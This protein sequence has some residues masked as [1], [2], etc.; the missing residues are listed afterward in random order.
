MVKTGHN[1]KKRDLL[2]ILFSVLI[3]LLVNY[4]G[5]FAFH[6][7]D[8]TSE[9]RY[10]LNDETKKLLK[11]L[12]DVV[13][14]KVYLEGDFNS[15]FKRLRNATKEIL[16]EFRAYSN[17]EI[18]YEFINPSSNPDQSEKNKLYKQLYTKG[19][20]PVDLRDAT[21]EG[22]KS[23]QI[24]FPGAII[25]HKGHDVAW[26]L[27]Q[28]QPG[29]SPDEQ[30]NNS[31]QSLEYG[32]SNGIRKL[33]T[34]IKK[35]IAFIEGHGELD[36]L[37]TK[38]IS[39]HLNEYYD[40]RRVSI[41]SN[42]H[43]LDGYKC[44]IIAKPDSTFNEKDKFIIDQFIMKGGSV[45]WLIDPLYTP[46]DSLRYYGQTYSLPYELNIEDQLF[47]YGVRINNNLILDI[48]C[49][50]I[51]HN[52][53]VP[54]QRPQLRRAPWFFSPLINYANDHI[55]T[56]NLDLIKFEY[57]SSIDTVKTKLATKKTTL[58]ASSKYSK[59]VNAPVRINLGIV[60]MQPDQKQFNNS[61]IPVALLVEGNFESLYKNRIPP[62]IVD[63]KEIGY[64]AES[65]T[66][67]M[68]F[69]SDGDII[70]NDYQPN[71]SQTF[72]LGFD[73]NRQY[74]YANKNFILNSINYLCDDEGL[75]SVRSREVKLRLL[76]KTRIKTESTKWQMI[77]TIIPVLIIILLGFLF[78]YLRNKKYT[79]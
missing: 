66:T 2:N 47:K 67:K 10:T 70:R 20:M 39:D 6:R 26:Q 65:K 77:N 3:L 75:I 15:G 59:F 25:T 52:V 58:L 28:A 23:S 8:L 48:Q 56:K 14:V 64:K 44:I 79:N 46:V 18:E 57:A 24:I 41:D 31:V 13:F 62:Q 78:L 7:F 19:L 36:T 55:I 21:E 35:K 43:A 4:I 49:S 30:L 63:N 69:V 53:A 61:Y 33:Q 54:G 22:G 27:L 37:D 72:P 68:I 50:E 45:L 5:S 9:K 60:N 12:D 40:T 38:D 73:F 76:D 16:D 11:E 42:I 32:L 1:K 17:Q 71:S 74:I 34:P 51:R 29:L